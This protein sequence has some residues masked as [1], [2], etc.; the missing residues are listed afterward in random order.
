MASQASVSRILFSMGRDRVL[1]ARIFGTVGR[2]FGAPVG[3]TLAVGVIAL[4]AL[5]VSLTLAA[6]MISFGALV[7]FSFVNLS[8]IKIFVIDQ[9]RRSGIDLLRY[10]LLPGIGFLLTVWLWTSLSATTFQVGLAWLAGGFLYLLVLTRMF[11]GALPQLRL[12]EA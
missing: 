11:T 12:E 10:G 8:V 1:P 6:N 7:A 9:R 2:R 5:V 4:L 3:A